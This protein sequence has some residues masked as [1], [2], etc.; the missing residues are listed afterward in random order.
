MGACRSVVWPDGE[1]EVFN[2][3]YSCADSVNNG[4]APF[5]I[6]SDEFGFTGSQASVWI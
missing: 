3:L 6:S 2:I 1:A 4:F 5:I